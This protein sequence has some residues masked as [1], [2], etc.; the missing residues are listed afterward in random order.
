MEQDPIVWTN[1][2]YLYLDIDDRE[3]A[4]LCFLKAQITDPDYA[5]AWFGQGLLADREGNK[6]Q[7]R[8][9]FAHSVTLSA[10]S[11]VRHSSL[12]RVLYR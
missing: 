2:G 11:L 12:L 4:N 5:R 3:L 8:S 6:D 10:S 9:L 1:L 7:A